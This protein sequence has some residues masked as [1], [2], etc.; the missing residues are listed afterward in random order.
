MNKY[1]G[2]ETG[3]KHAAAAR[4]TGELLQDTRSGWRRMTGTSGFGV[5]A[6][7][8]LAIAIGTNTALF[9]VVEAL[10]LRSTPHAEPAKL[11]NIRLT[12]PEPN[13]GTFSYPTFRELESATGEAFDGVAGAALNVIRLEDETGMHD[14]PYHELVAGS[15]F[16]VMGVDAQLGRVFG[17]GEDTTAAGNPVVVLSDD[18]WRRKFD[19]D[20]GIVGRTVRLNGFPYTIVG[21]AESGFHGRFPESPISGCRSRMPTRSPSPG[22]AVWRCAVSGA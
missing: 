13:L 10:I 2:P 11:V 14:S 21:V 18:T 7:A 6:V 16:Q 19:G 4:W 12:G 5:V 1:A 3:Q 20:R 8:L 15:Y 9:S 17:P 22:Q